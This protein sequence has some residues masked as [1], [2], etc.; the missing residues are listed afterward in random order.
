MAEAVRTGGCLCGA[1]RYEVRGPM[2]EVV[3]CHCE[4]CRRG[5]GHYVAATAAP[6]EQV[7]ISGTAR[8]FMVGRHA[9]RGF[10]ANC[11]AFLFWDDPRREVLSI[12][13]GSLD[14]PTGLRLERHIFSAEKSDYYELGGAEPVFE[15]FAGDERKVR[16]V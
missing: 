16:S 3:A 13:A 15:G 1:L 7:R 12:L 10:C 11:G 8:W 4:S 14:Q 9:R 6:R 5:S 2:R